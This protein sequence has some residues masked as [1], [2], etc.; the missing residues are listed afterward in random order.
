[1]ASMDPAKSK[2]PG[3]LKLV[4]KYKSTL[5]EEGAEP[6]IHVYFSIC[7]THAIKKTSKLQNHHQRATEAL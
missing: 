4:E 3:N 6:L 7:L 5:K 2:D 1:M